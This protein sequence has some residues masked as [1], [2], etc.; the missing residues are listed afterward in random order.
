[1]VRKR[2]VFSFL[3]SFGF[4]QQKLQRQLSFLLY[5]AC[6][7]YME[8]SNFN[9]TL[10]IPFEN[11]SSSPQESSFYQASYIS[12]VLFIEPSYFHPLQKKQPL[13][14]C[15]NQSFLRLTQV[16]VVRASSL[17]FCL[18]ALLSPSNLP[19]SCIEFP[20]AL[21]TFPALTVI[22]L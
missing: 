12:T 1:M 9:F 19:F 22:S 20:F 11:S 18:F 5:Q 16:C 10:E 2:W 13:Q 7:I 4:C 14:S 6:S 15:K 21:S 8:Q 17:P 3:V